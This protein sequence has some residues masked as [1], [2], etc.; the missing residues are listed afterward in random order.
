MSQQNVEI[1]RRMIGLANR[2]DVE[3]LGALLALD[4]EC[5]PASDQPESA[6]FRGREAF[7]EY[8][9][10]WLEVIDRYVIEPS[11][12]LD[13]GEYVVVVARIA[14]RG[15]GSGVE[16]TDSEAWLYRF[17]DGKAIEYRECGTKAQALEAVDRH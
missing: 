6:S 2:G 1:V 11:E 4:I 16:I 8:A 3:E 12:Y 14:A 17:R 7:M 10:G 15:R 9:Q 13:L 5:F